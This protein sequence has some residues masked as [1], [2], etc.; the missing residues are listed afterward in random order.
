MEENYLVPLNITDL[1]FDKPPFTPSLLDLSLS[2][3]SIYLDFKNTVLPDKHGSDHRPILIEVNEDEPPDIERTPKWNFK[4]ADWAAF[5]NK[6]LHAINDELFDDVEDKMRTFSSTLLDI[7]SEYIPKTSPFVKKQSKPWF[8]EECQR[9]KRERNNAE[10]LA[11]RYPNMDNR[12]R[13]KLMQAKARRLFRQKKRESWRNYVSSIDSRTNTN[14]VWNMI[15]KITGKMFQVA[16]TILRT[17][18]EIL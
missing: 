14:K 6:C 11:K 1:T 10:R 13:A 9:A 7:A 15:R 12:I 17:E 4:K 2:H 5:K 18:M 16:C 3:P 8:D